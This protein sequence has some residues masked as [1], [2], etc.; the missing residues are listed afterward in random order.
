MITVPPAETEKFIIRGTGAITLTDVQREARALTITIE[1]V[2]PPLAEEGLV[3]AYYSYATPE[4]EGHWGYVQ[5]LRRD[6]IAGTEQLEYR[7]Q[8]L[9]AEDHMQA[10]LMARQRCWLEKDHDYNSQAFSAILGALGEVGPV[11]PGTPNIAEL[12]AI[13]EAERET[14][15]FPVH[16][17]TGIWY[18]MVLPW[19]G[20]ITI[21]WIPFIGLNCGIEPQRLPPGKVPN[22][23]ESG[24]L[25]EREGGLPPEGRASDPLA[26]LPSPP[27]SG[28]PP[29][30]PA[31]TPVVPLMWAASVEYQPPGSPGRL[32]ALGYSSPPALITSPNPY[33]TGAPQ[34]G[35]G[36]GPGPTRVGFYRN[37][38][39]V[40]DFVDCF[41][42]TIVFVQ[43]PV[44]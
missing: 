13:W 29:A 20:L 25:G 6:F 43:V 37:G 28:T 40:G 4:P 11:V 24:P 21:T 41:P 27:Q 17:I 9:V 33:T 39:Y 30:S 7:R 5:Y 19:R 32:T 42:A 8:I 34:G 38:N 16:E 15:L 12:D 2:R 18:K 22:K 35:S 31:E 44:Q 23:G 14:Q 36:G 10:E 3:N 1:R 26:E